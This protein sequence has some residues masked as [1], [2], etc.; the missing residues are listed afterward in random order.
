MAPSEDVTTYVS[1][2]QT[3]YTRKR[4]PLPLVHWREKQ[5][6]PGGAFCDCPWHKIKLEAI[7]EAPRF[8]IEVSSRDASLVA[9]Y[10]KW[11]E[12]AS[13]QCDENPTIPRQAGGPFS[14]FYPG[15]LSSL[16][17]KQAHERADSMEV[18]GT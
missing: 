4:R 18:D 7:I 8:C 10:K 14:S 16:R 3:D 9:R 6:N 13:L 2:P 17:H 12:N 11:F 15:R 1:V 5:R